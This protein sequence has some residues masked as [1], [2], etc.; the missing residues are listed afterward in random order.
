MQ[1]NETS[2]KIFIPS[3]ALLIAAT[4]FFRVFS[5]LD[6]DDDNNS[7]LNASICVGGFFYACYHLFWLYQASQGNFKKDAI[8]GAVGAGVLCGA[9]NYSAS[10]ELGDQG[11][12]L[13]SATLSG[14]L[15]GGTAGLACNLNEIKLKRTDFVLIVLSVISWA[16]DWFSRWPEDSNTLGI[17]A[18]GFVSFAEA[19]GVVCMF[20][21]FVQSDNLEGICRLLATLLVY[22]A[23]AFGQSHYHFLTNDDAQMNNFSRKLMLAFHA[24]L[25]GVA[26]GFSASGMIDTLPQDTWMDQKSSML[27]DAI[28]SNKNKIIAP[29]TAL[30]FGYAIIKNQEPSI[31]VVKNA[32]CAFSANAAL[33]YWALNELKANDWL[34]RDRCFQLISGFFGL[35]SAIPFVPILTGFKSE[36]SDIIDDPWAFALAIVT[37]MFVTYAHTLAIGEIQDTFRYF[38]GGDWKITILATC[39]ALGA[40]VPYLWDLFG[41]TIDFA[42]LGWGSAYGS[43]CTIPFVAFICVAVKS[44]FALLIARSTLSHREWRFT[45]GILFVCA[46]AAS[47]ALQALEDTR[48]DHPALRIVFLAFNAAV[49]VVGFKD[50]I[51]SD[52]NIAD[53]ADKADKAISGLLAASLLFSSIYAKIQ[54]DPDPVYMSLAAVVDGVFSLSLIGDFYLSSEQLKL[55]GL[56]LGFIGFMVSYGLMENM[57]QDE[58]DFDQALSLARYVPLMFAGNMGLAMRVEEMIGAKECKK[59]LIW[60]LGSIF[61][62]V[63]GGV[64]SPVLLGSDDSLAQLLSALVV[65]SA[66]SSVIKACASLLGQSWHQTLLDRKTLGWVAY[67]GLCGFAVSRDDVS[68]HE[69][70][71][72]ALALSLAVPMLI[73]CYERS[74]L[75]SVAASHFGANSPTQSDNGGGADSPSRR[76]SINSTSK[77]S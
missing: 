7:V 68:P 33:N 71:F 16:T 39:I 74:N 49:N 55:V 14:V 52:N 17:S 42:G 44:L 36:A 50:L 21:K 67:A 77:R 19:I 47:T 57:A 51:V 13:A 30:S 11:L 61:S 59:R 26:H 58:N 28:S 62:A 76:S 69:K 64:A 66:S 41:F 31:S 24:G 6:T 65:S 38:K 20:K 35:L 22:A 63:I 18:S 72:A 45:M 12:A 37:A 9:L 40:S 60:I 27:K 73:D 29:V 5:E 48:L 46:G 2:T 70:V 15:S 32:L 3:W 56:G 53:K 34:N 8:A 25:F 23:S 43:V 75:A 10:K 4:A 54:M 1:S